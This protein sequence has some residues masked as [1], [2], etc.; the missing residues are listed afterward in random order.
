MIDARYRAT[1]VISSKIPA[2]KETLIEKYGIE[3]Q[4]IIN[5]KMNTMTLIPY[6]NT[7]Q[8]NSVLSTIISHKTQEYIDEFFIKNGIEPTDE[9]TKKYFV[10]HPSLKYPDYFNLQKILSYRKEKEYPPYMQETLV[11][12]I[13]IMTGKKVEFRSDEFNRLIVELNKYRESYQEFL[14]RYDEIKKEYSEIIL[15]IETEEKNKSIIKDRYEKEYLEFIKQFMAKEDHEQLSNPFL[16]AST[17]SCYNELI[18]YSYYSKTLYDAFTKTSFELLEGENCY[19]RQSIVKDQIEYFNKHGIE[20]SADNFEEFRKSKEYQE[21]L[22]D[23]EI[24]EN[25]ISKIEKKLEMFII[26]AI[27]YNTQLNICQ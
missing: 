2:I 25:R 15:E 4:D 26:Y 3:Y 6:F 22:P 9:N 17:L 1:E 13:E 20:V 23:L 27:Y 16:I 19:A 8:T 7:G 10:S 24:V 5:E 14:A 21:N 11:N 18:N 12:C